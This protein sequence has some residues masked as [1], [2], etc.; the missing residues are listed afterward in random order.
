[1][2]LDS[3][4]K[5][6]QLGVVPSI[7]LEELTHAAPLAAALYE[8]GL[9]AAEIS[10]R[11][12]AGL[13]VLKEVAAHPGLLIGAGHVINLSQAQQAIAAGAKFI[14]SPGLDA[15]MVRFCQEQ[16]VTIIP[17][18]CSPTDVMQAARLGLDCVSFFPCDAM[19]G[20]PLL[21]ALYSAFPEMRFIPNGGMSLE[22]MPEFLAFKPVLAVS[23]NWMVKSEWLADERF[24]IISDACAASMAIVKQTKRRIDTSERVLRRL[25]TSRQRDEKGLSRIDKAVVESADA[26]RGD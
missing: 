13:P 23:G 21:K 2:P 10:L 3:L 5:I 24:D 16:T 7:V 14:M 25:G 20:M 17:G 15:D 6:E 26:F 9:P 11:T 19:G 8:G 18:A 22:G 12:P 4:V 1:M